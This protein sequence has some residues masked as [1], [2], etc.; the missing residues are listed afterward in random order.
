MLK[1]DRFREPPLVVTLQKSPPRGR[2]GDPSGSKQLE[3]ISVNV[4][5]MELVI[6]AG[7]TTRQ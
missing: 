5:H 7:A 3:N 4:D 1:E 2:A 6:P